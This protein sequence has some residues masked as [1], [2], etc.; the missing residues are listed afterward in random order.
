[1]E[2]FLKIQSSGTEFPLTKKQNR[3]AAEQRQQFCT[4]LFPEFQVCHPQVWRKCSTG[5]GRRREEVCSS[6]NRCAN[7]NPNPPP[8]SSPRPNKLAESFLNEQLWDACRP[9]ADKPFTSLSKPPAQSR[10]G[11]S[12]ATSCSSL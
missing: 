11:F 3:S 1:M 7:A 10:R 4:C 9:R 5:D 6:A 2:L 8:A 12:L